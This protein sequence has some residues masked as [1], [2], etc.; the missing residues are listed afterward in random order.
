MDRGPP[1][2]NSHGTFC[3]NVA[4]YY[5]GLFVVDVRQFVGTGSG[6][7]LADRSFVDIVPE[8]VPPEQMESFSDFMLKMLWWLPEKRE[9]GEY[10]RDNPELDLE[11]QDLD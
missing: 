5:G 7:I 1:K 11:V 9:T 10:L 2:L 4:A 8:C 3:N 6:T